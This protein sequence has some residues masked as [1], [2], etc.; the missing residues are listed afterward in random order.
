MLM[1]LPT[2]QALNYP[3]PL[4]RRSPQ[5]IEEGSQNIYTDLGCVDA[6]AMQR[7]AMLVVP[8]GDA[9]AAKALGLDQASAVTGTEVSCLE[10]WLKGDFR[11]ADEAGLHACLRLLEMQPH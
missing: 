1:I 8:I 10:A 6:D 9:I 3:L 11:H 7:K 2:P 5:L 4:P